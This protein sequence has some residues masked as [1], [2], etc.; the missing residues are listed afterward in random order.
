[1]VPDLTF[2]KCMGSIEPIKP[3]LTVPLKC[4]WQNAAHRLIMS[5]VSKV[6]FDFIMGHLEKVFKPKIR[7]FI[8]TRCI[9]TPFLFSEILTIFSKTDDLL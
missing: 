7:V 6:V 8:F 5:L 2:I 4:K 1:M 9:L 3:M